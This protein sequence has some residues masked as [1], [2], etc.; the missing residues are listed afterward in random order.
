MGRQVMGAFSEMKVGQ[1]N[2][3]RCKSGARQAQETKQNKTTGCFYSLPIDAFIEM[4][5][6]SA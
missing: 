4:R 5:H 2:S 1:K 6:E 3:M